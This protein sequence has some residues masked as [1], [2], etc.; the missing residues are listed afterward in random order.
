MEYVPSAVFVGW[1]LSSILGGDVTLPGGHRQLSKGGV[2]DLQVT[3]RLVAPEP[4]VE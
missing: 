2:S 4:C 3:G 1:K